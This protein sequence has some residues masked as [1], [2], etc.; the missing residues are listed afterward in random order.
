MEQPLAP[1]VLDSFQELISRRGYTPDSAQVR[2]A[3][4]LDRLSRELA[5]LWRRRSI[6]L[7]RLLRNRQRPIRGLY[8]HGPVGRGKTLLMDMFF[9]S[10]R[11][12]RKRRLHFNAF[13]A[14]VHDRIAGARKQHSGDP[15][16]IVAEEFAQSALLLCL[17][18]LQV[19]DIAD[20]MILGRL[21]QALLAMGI[22]LVTTSN[23]AP[24]DLYRDGLSRDLFLPFIALIEERLD[25]LELNSAKDY[26]LDRLM[27]QRL[28][29]A[30]FGPD[31]ERGLRA[32]WLRL[33]GALHGNLARLEI[34]GHVLELPEAAAGCAWASFE[35]LCEQPLGG[36]DYLALAQRFHTLFLS[37]IPRLTPE[38]R[39]SARRFATLIDVLYDCRRRLIATA[40][41][42]P[43][44]LYP[45]D[46]GSA[47]FQRTVSRLYEMRSESYLAGDGRA[48]PCQ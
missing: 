22:V 15:M 3:G 43:D 4:H 12:E 26:R 6:G 44:Q 21:F 32:A 27:G 9:D 47:A 40:E 13:M 5:V 16:P 38:R 17:D 25:V 48:S 34:K 7:T 41:A 42:E 31:A 37:G 1:N 24:R 29:F 28:W 10:V 2:I 36:G 8:I 23:T 39:N 11:V 46:E 45:A 18:E 35:G 14:E 20:A 33:T 30:P 19:E